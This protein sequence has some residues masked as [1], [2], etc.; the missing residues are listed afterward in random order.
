M[1]VSGERGVR[2][3]SVARGCMETRDREDL[4]VPSIERYGFEGLF[5]RRV[6]CRSF[7]EV[8]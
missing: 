6:G 2:E 7:V 8:E 1:E 4:S 5:C 3:A